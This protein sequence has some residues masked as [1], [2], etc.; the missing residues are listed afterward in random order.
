MFG[1]GVVQVWERDSGVYTRTM[2]NAYIYSSLVKVM[3]NSYCAIA[4]SNLSLSLQ[5][6]SLLVCKQR[7]CYHHM[8]NHESMITIVIMLRTEESLHYEVLLHI[9]TYMPLTNRNSQGCICSLNFYNDN[10]QKILVK[11]T[12]HHKCEMQFRDTQNLGNIW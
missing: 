9:H 1:L 12:M 2:F 10:I 8:R 6:A 5:H 4:L 7:S 11:R 3:D